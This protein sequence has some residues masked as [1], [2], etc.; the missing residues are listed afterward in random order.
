MFY[1]VGLFGQP[2][3]S[4]STCGLSFPGVEQHVFGSSE[5]FTAINFK[6]RTDVLPPI[7]WDWMEFLT[8]EEKAKLF[9]EDFS[10][11]EAEGFKRLGTARK[12]KKYRRYILQLK[13]D[14]KA[15]KRPEL[16]TAFLDNGTPF[17]EQYRDWFDEVYKSKYVTAQG[18]YDSI[19]ASIDFASEVMDF[20]E[21]F[22][23]LECN[24]VMSFHVA[25][26][27]DEQDAA[28]VNF[29]K[30]SK[31]GI[32][33]AKEFQPMIVGKIKYALA[34]KFDM[35]F[36]LSTEESPGQPNKYIAKLEADSANVGIAKGRIQPFSKGGRIEL[37]NGTFY[38]FLNKAVETKLNQG[39]K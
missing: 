7:K 35:A 10:D 11:V 8:P 32:R 26:A 28:K 34:G 13:D 25:M 39:G 4:K 23:S 15:G 2:G 33:Y 14:L 19:K 6:H 5:E 16:K 21:L 18:N 12:I 36:F 27:V 31:E 30:D 9:K 37:P 22:N 24:T 1:H 3:T 17:F 20:L 29:L 38:D